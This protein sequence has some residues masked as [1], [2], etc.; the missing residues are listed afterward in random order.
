MAPKRQQYLEYQPSTTPLAAPESEAKLRFSWRIE[1]FVAFKE[2]M[3]T[4]KIFS[5][6][7]LT[8]SSPP[9]TDTCTAG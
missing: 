1:N 4:R 5:K 9:P 3:E 7:A 8:P 6:Y 2:I